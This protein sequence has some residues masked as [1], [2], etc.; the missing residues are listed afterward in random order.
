MEEAYRLCD[1]IAIVDQG[2]I[3][4]E[5]RPDDLLRQ[6]FATTVIR[7]PQEAVKQPDQLYDHGFS[8]R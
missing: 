7:L 3:I 5:G 2:R 1:E 8:L 6:H 4:L